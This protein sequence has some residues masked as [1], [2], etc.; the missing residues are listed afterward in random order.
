[1]KCGDLFG[2][3]LLIVTPDLPAYCKFRS[4][5][6]EHA[7]FFKHTKIGISI[8][9]EKLL[10]WVLEGLPDVDVAGAMARK[11]PEGYR[12]ILRSSPV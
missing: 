3:D 12:G 4:A 11:R 7:I 10:C 1:M 2:L 9:W 8:L 5:A 6:Q